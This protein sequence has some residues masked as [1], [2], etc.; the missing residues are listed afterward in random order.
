MQLCRIAI[1][2]IIMDKEVQK[3]DAPAAPPNDEEMSDECTISPLTMPPFL[4]EAIDDSQGDMD[5]DIF[6]HYSKIPKE[7]RSHEDYESL[8]CLVIQLWHHKLFLE[9]NRISLLNQNRNLSDANQ[10]LYSLTQRFGRKMV[11][12]DGT[13]EHLDD[14]RKLC[15]DERNIVLTQIELNFDVFPLTIFQLRQ[16]MSWYV[17]YRKIWF[18]EGEDMMDD[19]SGTNDKHQFCFG[20]IVYLLL[21]G[22]GDGI[23][24]ME[25]VMVVC[26]AKFI[27]DV[28][29]MTEFSE[30]AS[31]NN[32]FMRPMHVWRKHIQKFSTPRYVYEEK[33]TFDEHMNAI[34][35]HFEL[36]R[37]TGDD[38]S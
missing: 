12:D 37:I 13:R 25:E 6:D 36:N 31:N 19:Y 24:K 14:L 28:V 20:E 1:M 29:R 34:K 3:P 23:T 26:E 17:T 35:D 8:L 5:E 22:S 32:P 38:Y 30:N 2:Y 18:K 33:G 9:N 7:K 10:D 15:F 4:D 11:H 27:I 16:L 21:K